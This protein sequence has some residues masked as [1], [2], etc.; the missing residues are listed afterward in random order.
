MCP[1]TCSAAATGSGSE[2][3]KFAMSLAIATRRW[4]FIASAP[5]TDGG[6]RALAGIALDAHAGTPGIRLRDLHDLDGG[7]LVLG[8]IRRPVRV[9]GRHEVHPGFREV[10]GRVHDAARDAPRERRVHHDLARAAR[11]AHEVAVP[12]AARL[13]VVGMHLED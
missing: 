13:R 8:A 1:A 2:P 3:K 6:R 10:E 12:D 5:S 9:L 11:N 4:T 7:H